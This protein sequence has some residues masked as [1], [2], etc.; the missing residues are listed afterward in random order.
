MRPRVGIR[1]GRAACRGGWWAHQDSTPS[2]ESTFAR[3]AVDRAARRSEPRRGEANLETDYQSAS[4]KAVMG[5]GRLAKSLNVPVIVLAGTI[6]SGAEQLLTE[7]IVSYHAIK[8]E[9]MPLPEAI[10]RTAELLA[11]T[12][13]RVVKDFFD[14]SA[15]A[16]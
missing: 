6:G 10:E 7:G 4:G 9:S 3:A 13:Q 15:T 14:Q 16:K 2:R 11:Q 5:V 12:A 1:L 8:P